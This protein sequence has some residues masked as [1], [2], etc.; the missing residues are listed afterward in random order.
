[1]FYL[2]NKLAAAG[3]VTGVGQVEYFCSKENYQQSLIFP[4]VLDKT[5]IKYCRAASLD[6]FSRLLQNQ[7]HSHGGHSGA[8]P[9]AFFVSPKF[10]CTPKIFL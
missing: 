10:C 1:M 4:D 9:L 7:V 5:Q 8:M 2:F 3:N 6:C